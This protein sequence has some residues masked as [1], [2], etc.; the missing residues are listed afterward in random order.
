MKIGEKVHIDEVNQKIHV[1]KI[2]SNQPYLDRVAEI[3][4][5][6][7]GQDGENRLAGSIPIHLLK[8]VCD[9]LG[10]KWDDVEARKDVVK[11]MLLSGDFDKLR[12]W[13]GTF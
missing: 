8:Q 12:V 11:R 6:G 10:V 13:K 3:K 9:K 4:R 7:L 5:L 1:E 2:Y